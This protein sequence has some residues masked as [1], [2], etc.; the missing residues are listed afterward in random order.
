MAELPFV[1]SLS[2]HGSRSHAVLRQAQDERDVPRRRQGSFCV[3]AFARKG[4][5][6]PSGVRF[7]SRTSLFT[8][9]AELVEASLSA[10]AVLRQAQ[11]E[12]DVPPAQAGD[13]LVVCQF[14]EWRGSNVQDAPQL[15]PLPMIAGCIFG[16][17]PL[18]AQ[19]HKPP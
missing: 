14:K 11:D 19:G 1:L 16:D 13:H 5:L 18:P 8:V 3:F 7:F 12:R 10:H 17:G 2:K 9:R 4:R 15:D 6:V